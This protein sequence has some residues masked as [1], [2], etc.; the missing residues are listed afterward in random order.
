MS[1]LRWRRVRVVIAKIAVSVEERPFAETAR[2]L[3]NFVD[4]MRLDFLMLMGMF[5]RLSL[6]RER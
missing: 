6:H 3:R 2:D 4:R 5:Y 1:A